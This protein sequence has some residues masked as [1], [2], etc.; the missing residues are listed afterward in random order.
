MTTTSVPKC[1]TPPN[2]QVNGHQTV[3]CVTTTYLKLFFATAFL[4]QGHPLLVFL[5][6]LPLG[7]LQVEPRVGERLD[8]RQQRL[9]E[10]M[11]LILQNEHKSNE[12]FSQNNF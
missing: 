6:V 11:K 10:R 4:L 7:G 5:E 1:P 2:R 12:F 3:Q 9:D 8:V